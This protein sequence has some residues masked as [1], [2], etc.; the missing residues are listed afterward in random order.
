M[1]TVF[2]R[3]DPWFSAVGGSIPNDH[4]GCYRELHLRGCYKWIFVTLFLLYIQIYLSDAPINLNAQ[5]DI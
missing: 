4:P 5:R 2:I 3:R 1:K